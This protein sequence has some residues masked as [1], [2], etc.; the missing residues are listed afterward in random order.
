[1]RLPPVAQDLPPGT[2]SLPAICADGFAGQAIMEFPTLGTVVVVT[3]GNHHRPEREHDLV[4]N[5]IL[6]AAA[7]E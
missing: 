7:G 2:V 6:P 5:H 1:M 3:S 4:A